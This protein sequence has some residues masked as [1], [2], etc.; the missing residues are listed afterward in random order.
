MPDL[1]EIVPLWNTEDVEKARMS[2]MDAL[3]DRFA[4]VIDG[5]IASSS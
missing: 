1:D 5:R 4:F 3:D 2:A